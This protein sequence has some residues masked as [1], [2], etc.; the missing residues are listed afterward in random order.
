MSK[1]SPRMMIII[2]LV[3]LVEFVVIFCR[4]ESGDRSEQW[5][6]HQYTAVLQST[7]VLEGEPYHPQEEG[8]SHDEITW[9]LYLELLTKLRERERD[10]VSIYGITG[11]NEFYDTIPSSCR[12]FLMSMLR[13]LRST[14]TV[15]MC[16][17][18][19]VSI[20]LQR[21]TS[22]THDRQT[23]KQTGKEF[24]TKMCD[25]IFNI[26]LAVIISNLMF[27]VSLSNLSFVILKS[28]V[29]LC[30]TE[31]CLL[32]LFPLVLCF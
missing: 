28:L 16:L 9:P 32:M 14:K 2:F 18:P 5:W 13:S 30:F 12:N 17:T 26:S 6:C 31:W 15:R 25:K 29:A 1:G 20:G 24:S 10:F 11:H 27:C 7:Q 19:P 3:L 21:T 4:A 23:D 8:M 22:Y